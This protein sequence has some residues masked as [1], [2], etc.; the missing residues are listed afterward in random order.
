[1]R[2]S[3]S[4]SNKCSVTKLCAG[5]ALLQSMLNGRNMHVSVGGACIYLVSLAIIMS[6]KEDGI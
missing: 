2:N 3:V 5:M 6:P 1:M 4:P